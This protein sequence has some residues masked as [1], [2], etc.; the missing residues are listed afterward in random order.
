MFLG[1]M[2]S[3]KTDAL[4]AEALR[5]ERERG[6]APVAAFKHVLD[7]QRYGAD[8]LVSH[9]GRRYPARAI[10]AAA[11][12]RNIALGTRVLLDEVQFFDPRALATHVN[13]LL[14]TGHDVYA[15]GL[16]A[17][18]RGALWPATTALLGLADEVRVLHARCAACGEPALHTRLVAPPPADAASNIVIGA[19]ERYEPACRRCFVPAEGA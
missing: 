10:S 8:A 12:L 2:F 3:G 4:I 19:A 9:N 5:L 15:A 6:A 16:R 18:F 7:V 17:D 13:A 11:E 1:S 14:L